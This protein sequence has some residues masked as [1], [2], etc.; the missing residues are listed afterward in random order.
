M[1]LYNTPAHQKQNIC[2]IAIS[3]D[4]KILAADTEPAR[5]VWFWDI[6]SGREIGKIYA[7]DLTV[8]DIAF[9]PDSKYLATGCMVSPE[10]KIWKVPQLKP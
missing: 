7:S 3:P 10:I 6:A 9:S 1:P 5:T 8:A 2:C 4:G